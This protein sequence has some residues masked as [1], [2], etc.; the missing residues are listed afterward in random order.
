[1]QISKIHTNKKWGRCCGPCVLPHNVVGVGGC[2]DVAARQNLAGVL[3]D[4]DSVPCNGKLLHSVGCNP[5][6]S[7]L[8]ILAIPVVTSVVCATFECA[9]VF[10]DLFKACALPVVSRSNPIAAPFGVSVDNHNYV[11]PKKCCCVRN[12]FI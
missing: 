9:C 7:C 3:V 8:C 11:P 10:V 6:V 2:F 5:E 1:M 4:V 12:P